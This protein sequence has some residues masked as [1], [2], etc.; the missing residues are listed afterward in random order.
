[1]KIDRRLKSFGTEDFKVMFCISPLK[2]NVH[3]KTRHLC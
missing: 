3:R 2:E 1:M